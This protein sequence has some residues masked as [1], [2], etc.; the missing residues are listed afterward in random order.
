MSGSASP[1]RQHNGEDGLMSTPQE[2]CYQQPGH[3]AMPRRGRPPVGDRVEVTTIRLTGTQRERIAG[4][5]RA[6]ETMAAAI[7]RLL[8]T[9]LDDGG[10]RSELLAA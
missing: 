5:T 10:S 8:D 4:A 7:R 9:A 2:P 3:A 1:G 6:G